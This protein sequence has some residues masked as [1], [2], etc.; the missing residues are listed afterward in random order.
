[1]NK[2]LQEILDKYS[3]KQKQVNT[4]EPNKINY[5]VEFKLEIVKDISLQTEYAIKFK[6]DCI[7]DLFEKIIKIA[8]GLKDFLYEKPNGVF[9][10]FE[11]LDFLKKNNRELGKENHKL[12]SEISDLK[13]KLQI[14]SDCHSGVSRLLEDEYD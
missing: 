5:S 6:E 2:K 7:I 14:L 1:M 10:D 4:S 9:N 12:K 8:D 11:L 13:M 3:I